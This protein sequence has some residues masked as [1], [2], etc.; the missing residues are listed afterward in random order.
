MED[1]FPVTQ[2]AINAPM[3]KHSEFRVLKL[4]ASFQILGERLVCAGMCRL[5]L[6][7]KLQKHEKKKQQRRDSHFAKKA[8]LQWM[9]LAVYNIRS[10][11]DLSALL[12]IIHPWTSRLCSAKLSPVKDDFHTI[13]E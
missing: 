10:V 4:L 3:D 5:S 7:R 6:G 2:N 11:H 9:R 1:P 13:W 12:R 8:P